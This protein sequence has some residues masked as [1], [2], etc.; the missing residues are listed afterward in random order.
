MYFHYNGRNY[1][2]I[3]IVISRKWLRILICDKNGEICQRTENVIYKEVF[4]NL[5][6]LY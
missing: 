2:Q 1:N 5:K 3:K 6:S 4:Q